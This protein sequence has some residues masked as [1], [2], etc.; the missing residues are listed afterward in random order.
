MGLYQSSFFY[1]IITM[2]S[3]FAEPLSYIQ[4]YMH[5]LGRVSLVIA[6]MNTTLSSSTAVGFRIRYTTLRF[7]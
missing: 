2:F 1:M 4:S 5:H 3:G 7:H 6:L